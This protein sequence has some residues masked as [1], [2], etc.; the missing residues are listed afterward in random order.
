MDTFTINIRFSYF[1]LSFSLIDKFTLNTSFFPVMDTFA[2]KYP[3]I[4]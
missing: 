1:L 3:Y 2:V 4:L